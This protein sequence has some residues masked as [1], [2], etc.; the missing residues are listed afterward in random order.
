[1]SIVEKIQQWLIPILIK[2]KIIKQVAFSLAELTD[3]IQI[4]LPFDIKFSVPNGNGFVIISDVQ[5]TEHQK[6]LLSAKLKGTLDIQC[7]GEHLYSSNIQIELFGKPIF[8]KEKSVIRATDVVIGK[9]NLADDNL[10][11]AHNARKIIAK[12]SNNVLGQI[13]GTALVF[14]DNVTDMKGYIANFVNKSS[15]RVLELH[16]KEI[17][18]NLIDSLSNGDLEYT[19]EDTIL[20]EQLFIKYGK[21]ILVENEGLTFRFS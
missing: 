6:G 12:L 4:H 18:S 16:R 5:L 8:I 1:M 14:L 2:L 21:D 17:E 9:I 19:L 7:M 11:V 10:V 15:H 13:M 20:D 3:D